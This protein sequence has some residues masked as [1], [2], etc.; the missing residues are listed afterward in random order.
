MLCE[1]LADKD[2]RSRNNS[3]TIRTL[4]ST[5]LLIIFLPVERLKS[6]LST[7]LL[8]LREK[9]SLAKAQRLRLVAGTTIKSQLINWFQAVKIKIRPVAFALPITTPKKSRNMSLFNLGRDIFLR[10]SEEVSGDPF[11]HTVQ[12]WRSEEARE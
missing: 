5:P 10:H 1:L 9:P 2:S 7:F 3:A 8:R 4:R 11:T 6:I 12:K